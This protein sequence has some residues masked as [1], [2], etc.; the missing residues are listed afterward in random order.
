MQIDENSPEKGARV[1]G[2]NV[3]KTKIQINLTRELG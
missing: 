1:R 2:S 3:K